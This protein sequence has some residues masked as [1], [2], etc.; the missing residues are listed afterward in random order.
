MSTITVIG[1]L[2]VVVLL[3]LARSQTN[4][5]A[6][7]SPVGLWESAGSAGSLLV[8]FEGGPTEGVYNQVRI[9]RGVKVREFG[10]WAVQQH[11]LRLLIMASDTPGHPRFGVDTPYTIRYTGADRIILDGPDLSNLELVRA[12]SSRASEIE[13]PTS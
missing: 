10:H 4:W 11:E 2:L 8:H 5:R 6:Q 3:L 12:D 7:Q 9:D 1:L 13:L